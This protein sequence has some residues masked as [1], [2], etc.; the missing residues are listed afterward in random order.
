MRKEEE[1]EEEEQEEDTF[2]QTDRIDIEIDELVLEEV[3]E[4][5][6]TNNYEEKLM[7]EGNVI[8]GN[9]VD[10]ENIFSEGIQ[11]PEW[12][13]VTDIGDSNVTTSAYTS[14]RSK[15][16]SD[17]I[18]CF[19]CQHSGGSIL[20]GKPGSHSLQPATCQRCHRVCGRYVFFFNV[21]MQVS[22]R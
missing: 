4:Q 22:Y 5:E 9:F 18:A 8:H 3:D 15:Y 16:S 12:G 1:V 17:R 10:D 2:K 20:A 19:H 13:S 11:L 6:D 21:C 14:A 7:Y